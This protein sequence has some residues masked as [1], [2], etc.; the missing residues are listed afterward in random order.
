MNTFIENFK[1]YQLNYITLFYLK[2]NTWL[3]TML[4]ELDVLIKMHVMC[5]CLGLPSLELDVLLKMHVVCLCLG[6]S[7]LELD[8]LI[9]MRLVCL[10][11]G[12]HLLSWTCQTNLRA[13]CLCHGFISND[14]V[15]LFNNRLCWCHKVAQLAK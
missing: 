9:K 1:M 11:V 3:L 8:V 13:V 4:I 15:G 7:F 10:C 5:L 6:L 2:K 14:P 12:I